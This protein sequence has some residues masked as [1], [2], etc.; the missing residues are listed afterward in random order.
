MV[1]DVLNIEGACLRAPN[2]HR[3]HS[4]HVYIMNVGFPFDT[5]TGYIVKCLIGSDT[6]LSDCITTGSGFRKCQDIAFIDSDAYVTNQNPDDG[7]TSC[8]A[9]SS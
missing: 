8:L 9:M 3:T 2:P 7:S 1:G 4:S 5:T 6:L